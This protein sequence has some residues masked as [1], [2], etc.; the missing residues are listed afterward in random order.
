MHQ[1]IVHQ[2]YSVFVIFALGQCPVQEAY[3]NYLNDVISCLFRAW[4][5]NRISNNTAQ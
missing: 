4:E 3:L 1:H 2:V 5:L